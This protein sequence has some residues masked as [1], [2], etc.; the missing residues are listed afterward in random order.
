[1]RSKA[2]NPSTGAVKWTYETFMEECVP[3]VDKNGNIYFGNTEGKFLIVDAAGELQKEIAV[4]G[5]DAV[6]HTPVISDQGNVYVE[7][8]DDGKIKLCKIAVEDSGPASS[9]WPMK[10]QNRKHSAQ[11]K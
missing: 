10:G 9:A 1:F 5:E 4:G 3:A 6:V 8:F 2:I 7:V 11:A